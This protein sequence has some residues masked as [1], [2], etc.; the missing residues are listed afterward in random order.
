V[1]PAFANVEATENPSDTPT[2]EQ[3]LVTEKD[4]ATNGVE[5]DEEDGGEAGGEGK[6][7]WQF[8]FLYN[9]ANVGFESLSIDCGASSRAP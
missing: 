6:I 9:Y 5:N 8:E 7:C 3:N 2:A 1:R 4:A